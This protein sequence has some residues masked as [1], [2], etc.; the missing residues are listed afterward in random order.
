MYAL[1]V[2]VVCVYIY[3]QARRCWGG[4]MVESQPGASNRRGRWLGVS[5]G[6]ADRRPSPSWPKESEEAG[7]RR[8]GGDGILSPKGRAPRRLLVRE[9]RERWW[10]NGGMSCG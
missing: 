1:L 5:I 9:E 4:A 8:Q 10:S 2:C 7:E 6:D 3:K